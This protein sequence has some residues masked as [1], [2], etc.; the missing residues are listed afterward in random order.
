VLELQAFDL[1]GRMLL[2]ESVGKKEFS[3]DLSGYNAG[4]YMLRL[5]TG[6]GVKTSKIVKN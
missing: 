4:I 5:V 1:F 2:N 3:V 6:N